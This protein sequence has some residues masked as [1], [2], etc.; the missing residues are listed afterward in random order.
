MPNERS[1]STETSSGSS[2]STASAGS[3]KR[4]PLVLGMYSS[5]RSSQGL[6]PA[7]E[8]SRISAF[9]WWTHGT[10]MR[11]QEQ[12]SLLADRLSGG[13]SSCR[14][15]LTSSAGILTGMIW[16]SGTS[17]LRP[18]TQRK[19][20]APHLALRPDAATAT[21]SRP[22]RSCLRGVPIRQT[23]GRM[24]D[25]G[26]DPGG[27]REG[28]FRPS[29]VLYRPVSRPFVSHGGR[30]AQNIELSLADVSGTG[31][32]TSQCSTTRPSPSSRKMSIPAQSRSPGHCW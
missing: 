20:R 16:R 32:S 17:F 24:Q 14:G 18:L 4:R 11:R 27:V 3:F 10:S 1:P 31:C 12:S 9:V 23:L 26:S 25:L 5:S 13:V 2:R 6:L 19:R 8:A 15:S 22:A 29:A 21:L 7:R 30:L 28:S